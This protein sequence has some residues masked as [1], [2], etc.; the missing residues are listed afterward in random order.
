MNSDALVAT[1][2]VIA[3]A[4][5]T[6]ALVFASVRVGRAVRAV[7][8]N[9]VALSQLKGLNSQYKARV[10]R[11]GSITYSF[12]DQVDSKGK[13]DRYDLRTLAMQKLEQREAQIAQE[14]ALRQNAVSSFAEYTTRYS[15]LASRLGESKIDTMDARRFNWIEAKL[16]KRGKLRAPNCRAAVRVEVS[17]RSPQGKNSY[18]KSD[19]LNFDQL[20]RALDEMRQI[21]EVR[22]TSHFLRQQERMRMSAKLRAEVLR[23]DQSRCRM[24]GRTAQVVPLHVDHIIPVSKGGKTSLENLQTLCQ[25][26]NLGKSNR[27]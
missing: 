26:C 12:S 23:R 24:C 1:A 15:E 7:R 27:F 5:A 22:T 6:V 2:L 18:T 20:V 21:R 16:F 3:A 13:F 14:V 17:Y 25:D 8:A 9:S 10:P 11:L 19:T 4:I